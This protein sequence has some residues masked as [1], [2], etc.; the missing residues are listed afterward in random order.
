MHEV[1]NAPDFRFVA[2]LTAKKKGMVNGLE[3]RETSQ[4]QAV[5]VYSPRISRVNQKQMDTA[6]C[7]RRCYLLMDLS[8]LVL[9][10]EKS[11]TSQ[12][13]SRSKL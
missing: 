13:C 1:Q 6:N 4:R 5:L 9:S 8:N 12:A 2:S 10:V 3:K 11:N 7:S